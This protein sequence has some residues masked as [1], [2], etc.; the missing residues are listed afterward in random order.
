[1]LVVLTIVE[2]AGFTFFGGG[3]LYMSV[4]CL[5]PKNCLC[6]FYGFLSSV[7]ATVIGL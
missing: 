2:A 1:M 4:A 6:V 5:S 3:E 7:C